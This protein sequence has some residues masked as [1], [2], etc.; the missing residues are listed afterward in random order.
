MLVV[1]VTASLADMVD[2]D[3]EHEEQRGTRGV[4]LALEGGE[5]C[6]KSTQAQLLTQWLR[7]CGLRV[8]LTR[9]PGGTPAAEAIRTVVLS[10][11]HDGLDGRVEA[12]LFAA[13][14]GDHVQRVIR[15]ALDRGDIVI[16]DRYI[17]SSIAYQGYARGLDRDFIAE[18]SAWVTEGLRP[19]LTIVLD[20][21]PQM[22]HQRLRDKDRMESEEIAF[23]HAVR[24]GYLDLAAQD[25]EA[26][27]VVDAS[28]PIGTIAAQIQER[29]K[30][31]LVQ[32]G[33]A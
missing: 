21:D 17:D 14:R 32:S 5:A 6:G 15:P 25:Q 12:L 11:D 3:T 20:L 8:V 7:D 23:H 31:L 27:L 18:L 28:L 1:A 16:T 4:F 24:A 30:G 10:S 13:A 22:S 19:N 29:V 26:Y 9:E 2:A 33:V